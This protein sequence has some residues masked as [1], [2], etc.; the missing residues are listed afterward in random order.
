MNIPHRSRGPLLAV[1]AAVAV[2]GTF[3]AAPLLN[4]AAAPSTAAAHPS[5]LLSPDKL[6]LKSVKQV[7]LHNGAVRLPLHKGTV[8]NKTVWYILTE[9]SDPGLAADLDVNYAAKLTNLG[10]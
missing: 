10:I 9:S 1:T 6:I 3:A 2:F 7:N 4:A 8:G 5:P